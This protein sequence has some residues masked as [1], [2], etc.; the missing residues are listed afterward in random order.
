MTAKP[1]HDPLYRRSLWIVGFAALLCVIAYSNTFA[2][3][4]LLDD[5]SSITG[6]LSL[7][8]V[9]DILKPPPTA[10]VGGRPVLNV[11]FALSYALGH[12]DVWSYHAINLV[13]HLAAGLVLFGILRRVL[14]HPEISES[15]R[16]DASMLAAVASAVW[17]CDPLH[18]ESVTY[19]SQRAECLM[20]LFYFL[21][22][23]GFIR[24]YESGVNRTWLI[25]S[26]CSCLAGAM[27][28]EIIATAPLL[29]LLYDRFF[30]SSSFAAGL[31]KHFI[32]YS[33]LAPSWVIISLVSFR[34]L[35]LRSVGFSNPENTLDYALVSV[36]SMSTYLRLSIW[37]HPLIFDYG[38][39]SR[40]SL[41]ALLGAVVIIGIAVGIVAFA[42]R[43]SSL[44]WFLA[45][46]FVVILLPTTS[47][48]PVHLQ[49]LA[50]HR[51]Y[52]ALAAPSLALALA[53]HFAIRKYFLPI[54]IGMA[55]ILCALTHQRN[56]VYK[57][58]LSLWSDTTKKAPDN[59]RAHTNLGAAFQS[60]GD[61]QSAA[62]EYQI[63][64]RLN[65][66]YAEANNDLGGLLMDSPQYENQAI[67]Y[68]ERALQASPGLKDAHSNL[69]VILA[70]RGQ[71][72]EAITHFDQAIAI[73]PADPDLY[74]N[75]AITLA[76]I[77]GHRN[78]SISDLRH[79]L[80][81]DPHFL[82][83]QRALAAL[84]SKNAGENTGPAH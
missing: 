42:A 51:M 82:P 80:A 75:R 58:E 7:R 60:T 5:P 70:K 3:P 78:Q 56:A 64:L 54:G 79:A 23:Y 62:K 38:V 73:D 25:I 16:R 33:S 11:T 49:P 65:P 17:L 44:I 47:I 24:G 43:L 76:K 37:P 21:T 12:F 52:L 22:F 77:P 69:A 29:I 40:P 30:I 55:V 20:G 72:A 13:I 27:T 36:K 84:E 48:V 66:H 39:L 81:L 53:L 34:S 50:E 18:T 32:Y 14:K 4:F 2:V 74:L 61:I 28:K 68:F 6:N 35:G 71:F 67:R 57:N 9:A 1:N 41:G 31:K 83:A 10:G 26:S 19:I 59:Y 8:N 63:A 46:W 15:V 45:L